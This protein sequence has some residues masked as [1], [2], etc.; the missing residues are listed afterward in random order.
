MR[1][2]FA[3]LIG[4]LVLVATA[5][6]SLAQEARKIPAELQ[7]HWKLAIL[8]FEGRE[9]KM[10]DNMPC[11]VIKADQ[12]AFGGEPLARLIVDPATTPPILDVCYVDSA[13]VFEAVYAVEG[14][15]LKICV[16][17]RTQGVK[18]RP[19]DFVTEGHPERR[20]LI[21]QRQ[22][23]AAGD[24]SANSPGYV[25]IE[26]GVKAKE[27]TVFIAEV[28]PKSPAQKAG[29]KK[30]D[31]V[32]KIGATAPSTV[33][34]AFDQVRQAR[35]GTDLTVRVRRGDKEQDISVRVRVVPFILLDD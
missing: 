2:P 8:G 23:E 11:W 13:R 32:A 4:M 22:E 5:S 16:N 19:L 17:Q 30:D 35:P 12:V 33:R 6:P 26:F 34:E 31:I 3:R 25:G 15:R 10:R 9:I 29:L 7:G 18:E 20:L 28:L 24:G 27:K 1:A 21:F 14:D